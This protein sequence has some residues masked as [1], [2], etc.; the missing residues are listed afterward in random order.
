MS[1]PDVLA[2]AGFRAQPLWRFIIA[3]WLFV[4]VLAGAAGME[5]WRSRA[6]AL[7]MGDR[8]L[9]LLAT[10]AA[11]HVAGAMQV[12]QRILVLLE[13]T[14][15]LTTQDANRA[16]ARSRLAELIARAHVRPVKR[17]KTRPSRAAKA[18]RVEAKKQRS[19]VKEGRGKVRLD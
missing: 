7:D 17:V 2:R 1:D 6:R 12:G 9:A 3:G 15:V 4:A 18:K 19:S 14:H 11:E 8:E 5:M 10:A 16:E 13:S